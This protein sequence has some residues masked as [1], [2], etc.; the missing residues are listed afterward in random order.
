ML[1]MFLGGLFCAQHVSAQCRAPKFRI[2]R[3]FGT[4]IFISVSARDFTVDKLICLSRELRVR[5]HASGRFAVSFFGSK[6]AAAYFAPMIEDLYREEFGSQLHA[7][8]SF[9][10]EK[11]E[12]LSI[13]PMGFSTPPSLLTTLTLPLKAAA[14]CN[15]QLGER[16]LIVVPTT[17]YPL[18]ALKKGTSGDVTLAGTIKADGEVK[19]IHVVG[20]DVNPGEGKNDLANAAVQTLGS[21]QFDAGPADEAIQ[22]TFSYVVDKSLAP[23]IDTD[24]LWALPKRVVITGKP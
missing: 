5:R 24:V 12:T 6:E 10:P 3:D 20:A 16:C 13:S 23:G 9:D 22:I 11:G 2:G 8:Y 14:H 21:W 1:L 15:L 17:Q 7:D 18:E 4:S 19:N